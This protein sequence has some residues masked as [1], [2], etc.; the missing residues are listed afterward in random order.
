VREVRMF[1][2]LC[3]ILNGN[4]VAGAFGRPD[5]SIRFASG[6]DKALVCWSLPTR[7]RR[8]RFESTGS[9]RRRQVAK[10]IAAGPS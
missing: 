1:G 10:D 7:T 4:M 2:G 8:P 6:R 5:I 3:F 9:P